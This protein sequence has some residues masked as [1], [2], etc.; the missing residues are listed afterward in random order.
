MKLHIFIF[1]I[2]LTG[3]I[4]CG[5]P[6]EMSGDSVDDE[7]ASPPQGVTCDRDNH[8]DMGE[9][10]ENCPHDCTPAPVCDNDGTCDAN[11]T[12]Q[13][14]P[15]DCTPAPTCDNDGSC[16]SGET[17]QN[18]PNDCTPPG[19]NHAPSFTPVDSLTVTVNTNVAF[20]VQATD[21]DNDKV[22]LSWQIP[23]SSSFSNVA[24]NAVTVKGDFSWTPTVAGTYTAK[25]TATDD[26]DDPKTSTLTVTIIVTA[27]PPPDH[28][29]GTL[30]YAGLNYIF[31]FTA[32]KIQLT[33]SNPYIV[34]LSGNF[35]NNK[36]M[37]AGASETFNA[38]FSQG[39]QIEIK[40]WKGEAAAWYPV[41]HGNSV[42]LTGRAILDDCAFTANTAYSEWASYVALFT[43][44]SG[45][46]CQLSGRYNKNDL[47]KQ[48]NHTLYC[49]NTSSNYVKVE[50]FHIVPSSG[51]KY[52]ND[53][54]LGT[55][56][57]IAPNYEE[58]I[59]IDH[60]Y[61]S[62]ADMMAVRVST[63]TQTV[64]PYMLEMNKDLASKLTLT[65]EI[66][67]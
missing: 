56:S 57:S 49:Y 67:D 65:V 31:D 41:L 29:I 2:L 5:G 4:A 8:C 63:P 10:E 48:A 23:N 54:K 61:V 14:C 11:E 47:T 59:K 62:I 55:I 38:G 18:C 25:F 32:Q 1:T 28:I 46:N 7:D 17:Q 66:T 37:E 42:D 60:I 24:N 51:S 35:Y 64:V 22:T 50:L 34:R 16:E 40:I 30:S 6:T 13:N 20:H 3:L 58:I 53:A 27:S 33:N 19:E 43:P 9:T 52:K 12:Q 21:A 39:Q 26:N 36:I 44:V 45:V 15:N